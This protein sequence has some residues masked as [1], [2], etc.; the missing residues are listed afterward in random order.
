[1]TTKYFILTKNTNDNIEKKNNDEYYDFEDKKVYILPK[2]NISYYKSNGLFESSLIEWSRQFCDINKTFLDIGAHS[3][4]YTISLA[5]YCKEV[6]S[7]E[8]QK[9]TYYTLCGSVA[10]SNLKN[11]ICLQF[12]LGST[13]QKGKQ[14]LNIVSDDGGGSSLHSRNDIKR[15]EEIEIKTLDEFNLS[16]IC[17]IK[18]DVE[19]NEYYVLLGAKET[20]KRSNFPRIIFELNNFENGKKIID[21][22]NEYGY[23]I[24][25]INGYANMYLA[26]KK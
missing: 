13:D 9:I 18:I 7:F 23:I 1:M 21:L 17:F 10:L 20:L 11:V 25:P 12:G 15:K 6:Y 4:T 3:G 5:S 24:H 14:I 26:A 8:P 22:L 19:D 2:S 16:N